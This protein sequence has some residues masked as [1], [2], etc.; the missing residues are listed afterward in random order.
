MKFRSDTSLLA[1]L[2]WASW[3]HFIYKFLY[4]TPSTYSTILFKF[5]DSKSKIFENTNTQDWNTASAQGMNWT[6]VCGLE[7]LHSNL[8]LYQLCCLLMTN[9]II[10]SVFY[11]QVE[12]SLVMCILFRPFHYTLTFFDSAI[13]VNVYCF[14]GGPSE[15]H[16]GYNDCWGK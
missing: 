14:I 10:Y 7:V 16:H 2:Y 15:S 6:Q 4:N 11:K 13:N 12:D 5:I 8:H 9:R 3:L 1:T